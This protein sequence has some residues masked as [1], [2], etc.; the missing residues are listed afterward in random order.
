MQSVREEG[1]QGD[2]E[3]VG[4]VGPPIVQVLHGRVDQGHLEHQAEGLAG[5]TLQ[6]AGFQITRPFAFLDPADNVFKLAGRSRYRGIEGSLTG[7]LTRDLSIYASG[8]YLDARVR[9]AV[10][11]TLVGLLITPAAPP[12]EGNRPAVRA[13]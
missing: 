7:E 11:A 12:P 6:L 9:N 1:A 3:R 4:D 8:Q 2:R 5:V 13:R 10:P